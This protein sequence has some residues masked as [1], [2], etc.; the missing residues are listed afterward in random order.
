MAPWVITHASQPTHG[1]TGW[2]QAKGG[3]EF[4]DSGACRAALTSLAETA[5]AV[6]ARAVCQRITSSKRTRPTL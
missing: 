2:Q 4:R 1:T 6:E 3:G 5:T